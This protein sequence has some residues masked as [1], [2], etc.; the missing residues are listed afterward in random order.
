MYCGLR[1]SKGLLELGAPGDEYSD[2]AEKIASELHALTPTEATED[3]VADVIANVWANCFEL[4]QEDIER[5][6]TALHRAAG[7][8]H[9]SCLKGTEPT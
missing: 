2:E 3:R 9:A 5:R 8:V 7:Q 6:E 1:T 4:C